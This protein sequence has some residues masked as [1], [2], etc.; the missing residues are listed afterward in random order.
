MTLNRMGAWSPTRRNSQSCPMADWSSSSHGTPQRQRCPNVWQAAFA[1]SSA[2]GLLHLA[3]EDLQAGLPKTF[4]HVRS[5]ACSY[6][7]TLLR[8]AKNEQAAA[9]AS[10]HTAARPCRVDSLDHANPA[11]DRAGIPPQGYPGRLVE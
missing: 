8:F 3:T 6:L 4:E 7:A 11:H 5:F 9:E 10:A 2:R 1:E